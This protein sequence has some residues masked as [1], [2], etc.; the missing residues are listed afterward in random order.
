MHPCCTQAVCRCL[1]ASTVAVSL[2]VLLGQREVAEGKDLQQALKDREAR[3]IR[4]AEVAAKQKA[5]GVDSKGGQICDY[6]QPQLCAWALS[7]RSFPDAI[8]ASG[9]VAMLP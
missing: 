7:Q 3:R 4:L 1:L 2:G 5:A 9:S 8:P 6:C